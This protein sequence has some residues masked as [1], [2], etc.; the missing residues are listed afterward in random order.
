MRF[1]KKINED[2]SKKLERL[3]KY[4]KHRIRIKLDQDY[5]ESINQ[6]IERRSSLVNKIKQNKTLAL[7]SEK[8]GLDLEK[9]FKID[10]KSL[11]R[12]KIGR[13]QQSVLVYR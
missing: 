7:V 11:V 1:T 9:E 3:K 2:P 5:D 13:R 4:L 6:T 10:R 12:S 8:I